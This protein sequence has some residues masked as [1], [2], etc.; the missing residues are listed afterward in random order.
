MANSHNKDIKNLIDSSDIENGL[1]YKLLGLIELLNG[2]ALGGEL[3]Q[4]GLDYLATSLENLVE[5][6]IK[7]IKERV[8]YTFRKAMDYG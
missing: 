3:S 5:I 8:D 2:L 7:L 4:K 6:D 1:E